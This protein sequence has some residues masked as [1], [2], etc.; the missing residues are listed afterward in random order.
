[1][2]SWKLNEFELQNEQPSCKSYA[3][4]SIVFSPWILYKLEKQKK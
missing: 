4:D 3:V 1:M 2:L